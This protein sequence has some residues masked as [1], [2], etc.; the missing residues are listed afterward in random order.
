MMDK[1]TDEL[2]EAAVGHHDGGTG[3]WL[4]AMAEL[5]ERERKA[6]AD[7]ISR[8]ADTAGPPHAEI[9]LGDDPEYTDRIGFW[10]VSDGVIRIRASRRGEFDPAKRIDITDAEAKAI[11]SAAARP[12]PTP[13]ADKSDECSPATFMAAVRQAIA[14][15][16]AATELADKFKVSTATIGRWQSGRSVPGPFVRQVVSERL[17][18]FVTS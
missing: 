6:R 8:W 2:E 1:R 7:R 9:T 18:T 17:E 12:C 10:R 14:D 5:G 15:G 3:S 13:P 4:G 11:A 16:I